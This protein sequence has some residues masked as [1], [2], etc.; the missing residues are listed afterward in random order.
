MKLFFILLVLAI[1]AYGM[2][3]Q[4]GNGVDIFAMF[5]SFVASL[6]A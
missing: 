2:V 5:W 6:G 4:T 3:L 1:I